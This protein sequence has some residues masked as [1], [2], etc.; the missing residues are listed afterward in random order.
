[1]KLSKAVQVIENMRLCEKEDA[2]HHCCDAF[3]RP[4]CSG[5]DLYVTPTEQDEAIDELYKF[6]KSA[7]ALFEE[8]KEVAE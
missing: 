3:E 1:M 6:A 2:A 7:L 5:C 4:K 8:L